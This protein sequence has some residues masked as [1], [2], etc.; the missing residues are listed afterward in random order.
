MFKQ[1]QGLNAPSKRRRQIIGGAGAMAGLATLGMP[2]ISLAQNKPIKIGMP[3]IL[4]GRVA[5]LGIAASNAAKMEV[6]KFNAAGGLNGRKIELIVR[7]S[8]GQPQE[9][10]RVARELVT[11]D[12]CEMIFDG[13]ASSGGFAVH[14]VA[15][16]LGMLVIHTCSETSA[17]SADPKLRVPTAFR[18]A[19]QGIHDAVV[20]GAYAAQVAKEKGLK[21][22]MTVSPDYAYGRDTTAEFIEYLKY[23]NKDIEVIGEVWPKLFQP[24]YSESIT[25]L[26][27]GRP[28]AIYSCIWGGDLTSFIDQANIYALFKDHQFFAVNMADYAVLTA[29]KS[30]PENLHSGNRYLKSFPNTP[31]NNNWASEY[32]AKNKELPLN[33][34]WQNAAGMQFLT[35]A[36][37]KANSTETKKVADALRGL[38]IDSPFGIN[39]KLTMRADDNTVVDYAVGWGALDT[40]EPFMS[41]PVNGSWKLI[42]E[43]ELEWK[44]RKGWA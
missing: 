28:Q 15:R 22:W 17:L 34:S 23:F 35:T 40:K 6:E 10:S 7:D 24:D 5:M 11:A 16:D 1:D 32:Q 20:G 39:G 12:G 30:V 44:K 41:K 14:E 8:K 43:L 31:A 9:A 19:R 42:T 2:A 38:T 27:Q 21:R 26:L 13:E 25:R 33:W 18:C 29:V 3:T 4:S 36:I 37:K